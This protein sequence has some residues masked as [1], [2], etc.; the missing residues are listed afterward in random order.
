MG[1]IEMIKGAKPDFRRL[2]CLQERR[3]IVDFL[4]FIW[5]SS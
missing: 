3:W 5:A 4:A 1:L 2:G